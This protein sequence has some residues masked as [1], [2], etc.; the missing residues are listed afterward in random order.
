MLCQFGIGGLANHDQQSNAML[1]DRLALIDLVT[2]ALVVADRNTPLSSA[3][4]K[5]LLVGTICWK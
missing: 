1:H 5:P 3:I 2:D 4:L